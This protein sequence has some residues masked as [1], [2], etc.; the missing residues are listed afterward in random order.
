MKETKNTIFGMDMSEIA[1]VG[2]AKKVCKY[3]LIA[4]DAD[5]VMAKEIELLRERVIKPILTKKPMGER[6]FFM[7]LIGYGLYRIKE[8]DEIDEFIK[9]E[10]ERVPGITTVIKDEK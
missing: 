10:I 8:L 7:K 5:F 9:R 1:M 2:S 3:G 4:C 6:E